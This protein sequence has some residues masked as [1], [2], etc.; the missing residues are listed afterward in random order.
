MRPPQHRTP[1][2]ARQQ[3]PNVRSEN[4]NEN[5]NEPHHAATEAARFVDE[6]KPFLNDVPARKTVAAGTINMYECKVGRLNRLM[7]ERMKH[8]DVHAIDAYF[9][10]RKA[11]SDASGST[12]HKEWVAL[13]G[14]LRTEARRRLWNP[15]RTAAGSESCVDVREGGCEA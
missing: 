4:E 1:T 12:L 15:T 14:V 6:A 13:R 2:A 5:E 8:L 3:S 9:A 11:E 7:P 10:A